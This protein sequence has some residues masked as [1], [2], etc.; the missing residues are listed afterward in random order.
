MRVDP[1][2]VAA[3]IRAVVEAEVL[4]R[5]RNL[6][7]TDIRTKTGP[8]DLVTEADVRAEAALTAHLRDLLPGSAVVGEEAVHDR[9]DLLAAL[10]R[11]SGPVWVVDPVDGTTNFSQGNPLF[12]CVVALVV[13]GE[14][15]MGW[16]DDCVAGQTTW[17]QRGGGCWCNGTPRR[18][19]DTRRGQPLGTLS[20]YVGGR[21]LA[22]ALGDRVRAVHRASSAAHAYLSLVTGGSDFAAFTRMHPWDHAAGILLH[23]EAGGVAQLVDGTAYSPTLTHG[24]PLMAADSATWQALAAT[25]HQA[26]ISA[27]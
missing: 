14:T 23:Q 12:A 5:F 20:G 11:D 3:L 9:P 25:I 1:E 27:A 4:P 24:L 10:R 22:R 26:G 16:I 18:L 21:P 2:T 13:D 6:A 7:K 19:P 17:A 15:V 8:F